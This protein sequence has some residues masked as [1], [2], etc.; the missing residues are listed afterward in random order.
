MSARIALIVAASA[1]LSGVAIAQE[2]GDRASEEAPPPCDGQLF[3]F[4]AGPPLHVA[5]VTLCS[6]KGATPGELVKMFESAASALAENLHMA[7]EKRSSLIAQMHAKADEVRNEKSAEAAGTIG[8]ASGMPAL[9][10]LRPTA[11]VDRAPEYAV[12]PPLPAPKA[13]PATSTAAVAS[14]PALSR[15]QLTVECFNPADLAG[16]APCDSLERE[17]VLT[18]HARDAVPAGTS[19]R[20]IRRGNVRAEIELAQLGRGKSA[21]FTLPRPVCAG[22]VES[23]VEIQIVRRAKGSDAGQV[24][25]S[26]GPYF[27]RC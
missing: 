15:P 4:E 5:K 22:V 16:P 14:A 6:K 23:K 18:V 11:P 3:V 19:L 2:S 7:P 17:T 21:Q 24:V 26:M 1:L 9:A 13:L 20:F 12:L 8:G 27:L 10:P 25:E